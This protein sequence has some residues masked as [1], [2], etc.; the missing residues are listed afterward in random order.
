MIFL[1]KNPCT[2]IF[3]S[4]VILVLRCGV[5]TYFIFVCVF[6]ITSFSLLVRAHQM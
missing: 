5:Y 3:C 1:T 4:S 6:E 2:H